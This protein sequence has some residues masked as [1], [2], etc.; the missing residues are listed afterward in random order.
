MRRI[1][2]RSARKWFE[3]F[4]NE[5]GEV[6]FGR[7]V[8]SVRQLVKLQMRWFKNILNL[9]K[10]LIRQ[11]ILK[12]ST[13]LNGAIRPVSLLQQPSSLTHPSLVGGCLV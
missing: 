11:T 3:E 13:P 4:P 7:G 10:S 1:K 6:I 5:T 2:G 9:T 12:R 8:I